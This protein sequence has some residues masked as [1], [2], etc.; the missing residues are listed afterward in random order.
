MRVLNAAKKLAATPRQTEALVAM[1]LGEDW[2]HKRVY[3]GHG[4]SALYPPDEQIPDWGVVDRMHRV[5]RMGGASHRMREAMADDD[6]IV[7]YFNER[8]HLRIENRPTAKGLRILKAKYPALPDID[9]RL[10]E[11]EA[12]EAEEAEA[13]RAKEAER[14][15]KN[16]ERKA[17][18]ATNKAERMATILREYQVSHALT[19]DQLVA[20]WDRVNR[21]DVHI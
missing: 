4:Y 14:A 16:A 10:A 8:G 18:E 15:R 3:R 6:L 19:N 17:N 20:I 7:S 21:E 13:A 1:Y 9:Q 5:Q 12:V 11:R 2:D